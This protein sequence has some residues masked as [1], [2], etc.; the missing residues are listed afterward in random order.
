MFGFNGK[1][2]T[3]ISHKIMTLA[4]RKGATIAL[5]I[6]HRALGTTLMATGALAEGRRHLDQ[7][8]ALYDA[9]EHRRFAARFMHAQTANLTQRG[10]P[11]GG[12]DSLMRPSP[13]LNTP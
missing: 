12:L 3:E 7:A 11:S 2:L 1:N 13:I 9:G 8:A 10:W 5:L 4:E 6:G